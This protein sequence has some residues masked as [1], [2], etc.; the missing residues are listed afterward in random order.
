MEKS[1]L[2]QR[3]LRALKLVE[4]TKLLN[5]ARLAMMLVD[6]YGLD[7]QFR[8]LRKK[9][10][11]EIELIIPALNGSIT[12]ILTSYRDKFDCKVEKAKNPVST[13]EL[14]IEEKDVLKVLSNTIRSKD[15]VFGLLKV[16]KLYILGK[17]KIKG[18]KIAALLLV[19]SLMIG[20]N[21]VYKD[22]F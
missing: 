17:V 16:A 14:K 12:F 18:S 3:N 22:K 7:N 8:R 2:D 9:E 15:N 4:E 13:I 21:R 10:G 5:I 1:E 6:L 11:Q 19:R 20:K